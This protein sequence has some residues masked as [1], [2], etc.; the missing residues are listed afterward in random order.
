MGI[1]CECEVS[2]GK[3]EK[4]AHSPYSHR[5]GGEGGKEEGGNEEKRTEKKN[6][7]RNAT[8]KHTD[9]GTTVKVTRYYYR[10]R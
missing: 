7:M 1:R 4:Y 8:Q 3:R 9:S 5:R 2:G 6:M 10:D